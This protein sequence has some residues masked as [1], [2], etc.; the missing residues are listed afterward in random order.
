[1][2]VVGFTWRVLAFLSACLGL[3]LGWLVLSFHLAYDPLADIR[4]Y[5]DA[6]VRLN[7]G[8]P[9][10]VQPGGVDA[11]SFYRYPPLLAVLFRPLAL[12]PFRSAAVL[13]E[14]AVLVSLGGAVWLAG[15]RRWRTWLVFAWLA[16]PIAWAVMVGQAQVV[17]T[18]LLL[19][20]SPL[21]VALA[22]GLKVFPVFVALFWLGRGDWRSLVRLV[23]WLMVLAML[24]FVLEPGGTVAYVGFL[25]LD[26]VGEVWNLSP[27]SWSPMV[28]AGLVVAGGVAVLVGSRSR[29]GWAMAVAFSVLINPRLLFYHLSSLFACLGSAR[30]RAATSDVVSESSSIPAPAGGPGAEGQVLVASLLGW[31]RRLPQFRVFFGHGQRTRTRVGTR[32]TEA[33]LAATGPRTHRST[34]TGRA[35]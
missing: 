27:Y 30:T 2:S 15:V 8:L 13:W 31:S 20:A 18:F 3:Y 29:Y 11:A 32:I 16:G 26:Q 17:V 23:A 6:G 28:W 5:Y 22:S 7:L 19:I 25:R 9:L 21:A 33:N 34:P 1:V 35:R 10:Y 14:A 24:L 4:A 12:L